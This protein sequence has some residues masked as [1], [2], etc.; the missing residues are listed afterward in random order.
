MATGLR[1]F[2]GVTAEV[3]KEAILN[4]VPEPPSAVNRAICGGLEA[5]IVKALEK[6]R[7]LRHQSAAD[8]R[9]DMQRIQR[10]WGLPKHSPPSTNEGIRQRALRRAAG[11]SSAITM[12]V[13]AAGALY[14][15]SKPPS[16]LTTHDSVL[17]ADFANTTQEKVYDDSL[18]QGLAVDLEQSPFLNVVSKDDRVRETLRLMGR[19]PEDPMPA[20]VAREVCQRLGIK[21][22]LAGSITPLG[23][24]YVI[25][26]EA[27]ACQTG[28]TLARAQVEANG[29]ETV[30]ATLGRAAS[31][32][33][34]KLGE[35]LA[36]LERFDVPLERVTTSSLEALKA[37]S[38]AE[39]QRAR[40][41]DVEAIPLYKRAIE[42]DRDFALAY[43]RLA[44]VYGN[45]GEWSRADEFARQSFQRKS[46]VSEREAFYIA[47]G[48]YIAAE[49]DFDK[50]G[51]ILTQ[52]ASAY[53]RDWYPRF[54]IA[55]F[56]NTTGRYANGLEPAREA[57]RLNPS[58]PQVYE[59]LA[60]TY[61]GLN[62]WPHA[63]ATLESAVAGGHGSMGVHEQLFEIGFVEENQSAVAQQVSF[64]AGR[65]DED[66]ML[67]SQADAA[68]FQGHLVESSNLRLRAAES[69]ERE[70]LLENAGIIRSDQAVVESWCGE[71]KR[72][73]AHVAQA[74]SG[75]P[76]VLALVNAADALAN[77]GEVIQAE[78]I[79]EGL[80]PLGGWLQPGVTVTEAM[81]EI[82]RGRAS[83]ALSVLD[84]M[85]FLDL[86]RYMALRPPYV[87]GLAYLALK[88]GA[89]ATREFQK[90]RDHRGIAPLSI[91]YTLAQLQ[92]AR[93]F[94][95]MGETETARKSYES[96]LAIWRTAD[97]DVP[98]F[99]DARR[100]YAALI[101]TA[102]ADKTAKTADVGPSRD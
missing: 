71:R 52:W 90:V 70:G 87:R 72:A 22:M 92:Q 97:Q 21:A 67:Q 88:D 58:N 57:L 81:L 39:E 61:A 74:T 36:T 75:N 8:L 44:A 78:K 79:L 96:F 64:A 18:R 45:L 20:A 24:H 99:K 51:E 23:K 33:R 1:P 43:G 26:L 50:Y 19:S 91:I 42:L 56:F 77:V 27:I 95:L 37:F 85:A 101:E 14:L 30:L 41:S 86:G 7:A 31:D 40:G 69:V 38:A 11:W 12:F 32:L 49:T 82:Q 35:S 83:A 25:G 102:M 46:R 29:P 62:D 4:K 100:E 34:A 76:S 2:A 60:E 48:Y 28:E 10:E 17:L 53:P 59:R 98:V 66:E 73:I 93:A 84:K 47:A 5:I 68:A 6:D 89:N 16:T 13:V 9:T 15:Y 54:A 55:D 3:V 94:V 65:P 63:K 80:P